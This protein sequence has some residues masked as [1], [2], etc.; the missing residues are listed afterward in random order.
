VSEADDLSSALLVV[1][2]RVCEVTGWAFGQA[3]I[4]SATGGELECG[5]AWYDER[6][7]LASFRERS[8]QHRFARG[9]GLPGRAWGLGQPIWVS[10]VRQDPNI[11]R[12]E[13]AQAAGIEAGRDSRPRPR[14][15]R[16]GARVLRA[17]AARGR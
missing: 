3:W 12:N 8:E 5:P 4:P 17:R 16:R 6:G 2:R 13:A 11:P 1:L 9:V 10:A 15:G 14:R 7:Q